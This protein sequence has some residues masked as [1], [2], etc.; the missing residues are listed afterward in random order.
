VR[1]CLGR[2][3]VLATIGGRADLF[4]LVDESSLIDFSSGRS[5]SSRLGVAPASKVSFQRN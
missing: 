2:G 4:E 1:R 5:T 3:L